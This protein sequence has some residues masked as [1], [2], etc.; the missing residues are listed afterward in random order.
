MAV[1][2]RQTMPAGTSLEIL[3]A[4]TEKMAADA[5]PPAGLIVHSQYE[6]GGRVHVMAVWESAEAHRKFTEDRL[7]PAMRT[8]AAERGLQIAPGGR[9]EFTVTELLAAVRGR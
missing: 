2:M 7:G 8:V 9:P 1:I 3:V 4:V 5:G 6:Q